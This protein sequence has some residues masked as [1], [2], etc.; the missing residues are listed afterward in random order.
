[1]PCNHEQLRCTNNRFFCLICGAEV[2]A[3]KRRKK[4]RRNPKSPSARGE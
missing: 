2:E 4:R 1:M 3:P